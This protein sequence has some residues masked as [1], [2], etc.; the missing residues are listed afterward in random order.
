MWEV[1]RGVRTRQSFPEDNRSEQ[2]SDHEVGTRVDDAD[3]YCTCCQRQGA[4]EEAPHHGVEG[5]VH[6]EEE[7][8]T[9]SALV[10]FTSMPAY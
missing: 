4:G 2:R 1:Q 10:H 9:P 7:L 8:I 3:S 5:E 6:Q